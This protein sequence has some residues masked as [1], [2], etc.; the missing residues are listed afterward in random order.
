LLLSLPFAVAELVMTGRD[1]G[2]GGAG[3]VTV[4]LTTL[5]PVPPELLAETV[6]LKFPDIVGLPVILF[7][8]ITSPV[9]KLDAV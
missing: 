3:F 1:E 4:I 8:L 7:P 5:V 6:T 9:G 2:S